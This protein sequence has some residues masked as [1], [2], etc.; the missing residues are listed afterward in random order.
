MFDSQ[1]ECKETAALLSSAFIFSPAVLMVS[2]PAGYFAVSLAMTCT[3][4]CA[5]LAWIYWEKSQLTIPSIAMDGARA[6]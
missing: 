3:A 6:E 4:I 5:A 1:R 2:R